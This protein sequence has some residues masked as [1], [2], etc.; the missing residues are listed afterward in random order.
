MGYS[1]QFS[2]TNK[3]LNNV[4][5]AEAAKQIIEN[6]PL[7][8][9]W[10]RKFQSQALIRT[11][12]HSTAIEGNELDLEETQK[13]IA[14][15]KVKTVR[16]RDV[17]EIINYRNVIE[18][19]SKYQGKT[20]TPELMFEVHKRLGEK[21]LHPKYLGKF[22][23]RNAVIVNSLSGEVIFD[24]P[25]HEDVE[26]EV[27]E[28]I[29]WDQALSERKFPELHPL[30]KAGTLHFELVRIH[31][32][33]DLNGRTARIIATWSLDRDG[34]EINRLFSLEEHYDQDLQ[35]YYDSLD[36]AHNGDLTKWL[37]YFTEGVAEELARIKEKV[38][39]LS[40][41]RKLRSK[42]GQ[43]ALNERQIDMINYIEEHN[44]FRNPDFVK[45]F[46][47]ISDDTILRDLK[48]LMDK[49]LIVKKGRTKAS[50]YR[51]TH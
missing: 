46:P 9:Y 14:G 13:I 47:K 48:D 40:M 36:D 3:I 33:V 51:L 26:S 17:Q 16:L 44:E 39:A 35:R 24:A 37:E 20:L 30:L 10:E 31:P 19:I 12:H 23:E 7:V 18:F 38:L 21:I 49:G 28:I 29:G 25:E 43:V 2:I 1:P 41:D 22:R 27:K 4:A 50:S 8:P 42:L 5:Q 34:Y 15:E 6:S 11:V 32:F 45:L